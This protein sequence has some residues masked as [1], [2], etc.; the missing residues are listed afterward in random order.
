MNVF[1]IRSLRHEVLAEGRIQG[2]VE[3][4]RCRPALAHRGHLHI[5]I[6]P[7]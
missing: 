4:E 3:V 2:I 7:A 1:T 5:A 6:T